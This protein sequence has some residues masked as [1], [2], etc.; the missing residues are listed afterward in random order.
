MIESHG[1]ERSIHRSFAL[2]GLKDLRKHCT[3][4]ATGCQDQQFEQAGLT[5]PPQQFAKSFA[6]FPAI[7]D[8]AT[9]PQRTSPVVANRRFV[10][11]WFPCRKS[12][13]KL[14]ARPGNF[15]AFRRRGS[16]CLEAFDKHKV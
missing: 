8:R 14:H 7:G 12:S 13:S 2:A 9:I 16:G 11:K 5:F 4:P 1:S 10:V 15:R 3:M 6:R